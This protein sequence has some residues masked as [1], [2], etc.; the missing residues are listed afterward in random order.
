MR[1]STV[2]NLVLLPDF[3]SIHTSPR[4]STHT[5]FKHGDI[6]LALLHMGAFPFQAH[7]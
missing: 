6:A 5:H 2:K 4:P 3:S 7:V 1:G